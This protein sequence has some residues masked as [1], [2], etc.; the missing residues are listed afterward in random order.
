VVLD[1]PGHRPIVL[2]LG[3]GLR[4]YGL[5]QPTDGSFSGIALVSHLH[6]DHIQGLPFFPPVLAPGA[7]FDVY[8]PAQPG[9]LHDAVRTFLSPPYFPIS[10][11]QLPGSIVFNDVKPGTFHTD[12][13]E[14]SVADVPHVGPTLGY[15]VSRGGVSVAYVSDHQQPGCMQMDVSDSVLDLCRDVDLLIHDAQYTDD[16]FV[17]RSDWGHCTIEY[18]VNVAAQCGAKRL[19]LFHHDPLHDDDTLDRLGQVAARAAARMGVGEVITA[20]EGLSLSLAPP[21]AR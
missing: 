5:T 11:D 2:D 9:G 16:E 20:S 14:I 12:G 17:P 10:V 19:A 13:A 18:A 7:R 6:W 4:F 21:V 3:T 15:R 1:D 8:G